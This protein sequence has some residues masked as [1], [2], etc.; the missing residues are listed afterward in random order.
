[1]DRIAAMHLFV[2][3]AELGSFAA[4]AQQLGLARS[5]VT[6]QIAALEAHLGVKLM[7]RSTRRL[8]LTSAGASYLEKCRVILHLVESAE[9]DVSAENLTPKGNIRLSLPLSFGL[10]RLAPLLLEFSQIYPEVSL[11]MDFTDRQINLIE[12]GFDLTIRVTRKLK[13]GD[14]ARKIGHENV[15]VLASPDYLARHG[16]PRHPV[17]LIHHQCLGYTGS[18]DLQSWAFLI[19]GEAAS[20][21]VQSRFNANNGDVLGE[22]AAQGL[23]IA[24]CPDFIARPF[25]D[26]QRVE[27]IL[28]DFPIPELG[29]YAMLPTNR[30]IPNRT[31]ILMDFFSAK[32][33]WPATEASPKKG[34]EKK[35]T[36]R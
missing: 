19:D 15:L 13:V 35:R 1:M 10:T 20:F 31:R 28:T 29:V 30:H 17:E 23:G 36:Q 7:A 9:S 3:V 4:V 34:S 16:R 25:F 14:I 8:S 26:A 22:A 27:A 5:A 32:L 24:Y 12:E 6:R 18:N 33:A 2:R 21:P 11:E